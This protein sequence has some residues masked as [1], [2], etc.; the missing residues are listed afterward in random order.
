[1]RKDDILELRDLRLYVSVEDPE[2]EGLG[3][4]CITS[5]KSAVYGLSKGRMGLNR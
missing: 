4:I 1:M 2:D 3:G 5:P